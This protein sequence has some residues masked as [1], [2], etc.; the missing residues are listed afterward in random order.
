MARLLL[1][2]G[3]SGFYGYFGRSFGIAL[4]YGKR[5]KFTLRL[6]STFACMKSH[7]GNFLHWSLVVA[8]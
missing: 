7:A 1:S 2:T 6:E 4:L 3:L 8:R 5:T